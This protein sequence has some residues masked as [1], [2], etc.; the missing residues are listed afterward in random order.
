MHISIGPLAAPIGDELEI[1]VVERKGL[2]HPDS[3]CDALAEE[4]GLRL[5]RFYRE[6]FGAILHHNVDKV[7]LR[8]GVAAPAFGGGTVIEPIEIYLAGRAIPRFRGVNLPV[9]ELAIE[10]ARD[11][12]ARHF[13]A[14]EFERHVRVHCLVR[15]GSQELVELFQ[16]GEASELLA[17]DTSIGTGYAPLS[18]LE[19]AVLA[20]ERE[21]N[22]LAI[23]RAHPAIG[24]DV[25]LMAVRRGSETDLTVACAVIDRFINGIEAYA[26]VCARIAE[27]VSDAAARHLP[28][29]VTVAVNTADDLANGSIY[30]TVTGTSAEAGDDGEAGRGN[31]HNG[32]ITPARPMTM[33][34]VAGKNPLTHVGKTY[35]LCASLIAAALV[36]EIEEIAAAECLMVSQIGRPVTRPALVDIRL[37]LVGKQRLPVLRPAIEAIVEAHLAKLPDLVE[38]LLARRIAIDRWPLIGPQSC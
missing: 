37:R 10:S 30:L 18:T 6:R 26:P 2:G 5:C 1:E 8:G 17:N 14:L 21:L 32:L 15:P 4:F 7:L 9:D 34:S 35:N 3:I 38:D 19:T 24:Q 16:R 36:E 22:S 12:F 29:Q 33:E 20:A 31:R 13:H 25:K 28:G 27:I 23:R 11:W